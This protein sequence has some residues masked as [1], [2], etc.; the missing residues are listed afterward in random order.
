MLGA[1]LQFLKVKS[2]LHPKA[3]NTLAF[4]QFETVARKLDK[5]GNPIAI[6]LVDACLAL[7]L[8]QR[9]CDS[10]GIKFEKDD[11]SAWLLD[12]AAGKIARN[13][14]TD[15]IKIW[16]DQNE[17]SD[18]ARKFAYANASDLLNI[19]LTGKKASCLVAELGISKD[20]LRDRLTSEA[21]DEY[22]SI[23]KAASRAILRGIEP[24]QA[25]RD[26]LEVSYAK[27]IDRP[28]D[29]SLNKTPA[30]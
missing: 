13:Q 1:D 23:E 24:M 25:V 28:F 9:A 4:S 5:K 2:D 18:N 17:V 30:E 19:G 8:Y 10:F 22:R 7:S 3:V 14:L 20:S 27:T 11:R 6:E 29:Y 16:L 15:A 12:R 26:A 21:L